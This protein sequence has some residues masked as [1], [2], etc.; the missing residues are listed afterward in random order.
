MHNILYSE[1]LHM[2]SMNFNAIEMRE[3]GRNEG[4]ERERKEGEKLGRN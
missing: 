4:R 3:T 2:G 1:T